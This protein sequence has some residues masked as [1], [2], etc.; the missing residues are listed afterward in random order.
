VNA[1]LPG[2]LPSGEPAY[3]I[4]NDDAPTF[5]VQGRPA[6]TDPAV[7]KLERDVGALKAVDP[8]AGG[9]QVPLTVALA[10]PVEEQALHMVNADPARTPTFTMFGNPD[11]FFTASGSTP[12]CGANPCVSPGF[13]W[14]HGDVQPE[15]ANTWVGFVG[16]GIRHAGIDAKTWT[17]H[18]NLRP[19]ILALTG[20]HDDY[21]QDGR[22]LVE[23]LETKATPHGLV[24]HRE[25]VRRLGE[26]YEQLNASFGAFAISTLKASTAALE[27]TDEAGYARIE[28]AIASLTKRRDALAGRIEQQLNAAAFGGRALRERQA[29][30]EIESARA[31][32]RDAARL[33]ARS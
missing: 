26:E 33:A 14:N 10:D 6:R 29:K 21:V 13:A 28:D 17:D 7:R 25:T 5:Y 27:S 11:F 30:E 4:H 18:T 12:S 23:A 8:Y 15:I 1:A 31:I 32:I 3:A 9:K 22:V 19:T 16:P 24:A 2:L 20:L